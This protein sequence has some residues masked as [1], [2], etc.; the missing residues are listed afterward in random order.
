LN[1][2]PAI[3]PVAVSISAV[4]AITFLYFRVVI[5]YGHTH[6]PYTKQVSGVLSVNV[7]SVGK[8]K[9]GDWRACYAL[10]EPRAPQPVRF[11]RL[12]SEAF[13]RWLLRLDN[14]RNWLIHCAA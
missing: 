2:L 6:R 11:V 4:A 3:V 5:V 8:P 1:R 14:F 9:D 10:L 12:S 13:W 7:G